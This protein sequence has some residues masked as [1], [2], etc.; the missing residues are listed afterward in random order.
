LLEKSH[1]YILIDKK[2]SGCRSIVKT[3]K[4]I[5][6]SLPLIIQLRDKESKRESVLKEAYAL[7]KLLLNSKTIFI[8]NDYIDIAK[9]VN[10]DGIHLGQDDLPPAIARKLLGKD[11]IIGVSCHNLNQAIQA[12]KNGANYIS[13]GPIFPTPIKPEYK[14]T[15]L[16]L[17]KM[18]SE[19]IRIPFFAIGGIDEN[20]LSR[21]LSSGA[22]R[23]AVCRAICQ[24]KNIANSIKNF[25]KQLDN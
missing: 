17:I 14:D 2:V 16:N 12:Q 25:R 6:D 3:V 18:V 19:K 15:G 9:I 22:K 11:K 1:L 23:V 21:V 20:N 4:K 7:R 24:A 8:I 5:K 13:I 10:S